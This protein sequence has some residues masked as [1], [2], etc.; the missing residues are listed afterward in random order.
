MILACGFTCHKRS[1]FFVE[2]NS[3]S[4]CVP[5]RN[6]I[7][8][9]SRPIEDWTAEDVHLFMVAVCCT[10]YFFFFFNFSFDS[11]GIIYIMVRSCIL[12]VTFSCLYFDRLY[13]CYCSF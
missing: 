1:K 2:N 11:P 12:L 7:E 4:E 9:S 5:A 8:P 6:I 10:E 3:V 13:S